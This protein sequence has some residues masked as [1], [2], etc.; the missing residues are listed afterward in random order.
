MSHPVTLF[1]LAAA[2]AV[3]GGYGLGIAHF[4]FLGVGP[5]MPAVMAAFLLAVVL[6]TWPLLRGALSRR[7]AAG[8]AAVLLVAG[9]GL[10]LWVRL[11]APAPTI[12]IY[13]RAS[14]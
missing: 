4:T 7:V 6:A 8:L 9:F 13:A 3:A 1:L 12:P 5:D 10:A 2:G 14:T 11:D